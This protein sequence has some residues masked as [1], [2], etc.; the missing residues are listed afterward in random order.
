MTS[1]LVEFSRISLVL[2]SLSGNRR[3]EY[4]WDGSVEETVKVTSHKRSFK[5]S[6]LACFCMVLIATTVVDPS[7]PQSLITP[8]WTFPKL[9]HP[10]FSSN[11]KLDLFISRFLLYGISSTWFFKSFLRSTLA[12]F[13]SSCNSNLFSLNLAA[14]YFFDSI[15]SPRR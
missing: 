8:L 4:K 11:S 2:F 12:G 13:P 15:W 10:I 14:S 9:P 3:V 7:F 5:S 1:T 6:S